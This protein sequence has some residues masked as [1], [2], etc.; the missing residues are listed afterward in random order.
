MPLTASYVKL[1]TS[2]ERIWQAREL[3]QYWTGSRLRVRKHGS[4]AL[5]FPAWVLF[6]YKCCHLHELCSCLVTVKFI[7]M[8]M[9]IQRTGE[10]GA[11]EKGVQWNKNSIKLYCVRTGRTSSE[12]VFVCVGAHDYDSYSV[13]VNKS[14]KPSQNGYNSQT[15]QNNIY[16]IKANS[17]SFAVSQYTLTEI[18]P[19]SLL[20]ANDQIIHAWIVR[21]FPYSNY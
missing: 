11:L 6:W 19:F 5:S 16:I 12:R 7:M 3:A 17:V 15:N 10:S 20:N 4:F 14:Q 8:Q 18:L 13:S 1:C 2:H 21:E 9:N